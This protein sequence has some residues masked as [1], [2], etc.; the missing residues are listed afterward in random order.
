MILIIVVM[1]IMAF[2]KA[3]RKKVKIPIDWEGPAWIA[4]AKSESEKAEARYIV[5]NW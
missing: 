4:Q 3:I 1:Y 2:Q 5:C